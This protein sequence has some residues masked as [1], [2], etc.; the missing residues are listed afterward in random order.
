[1]KSSILKALLVCYR[2][3]SQS[4]YIH[5]SHGGSRW[6]RNNLHMLPQNLTRSSTGP[7]RQIANGRPST[8]VH[9]WKSFLPLNIRFP[10]EPRGHL[11][12]Q[13]PLLDYYNNFYK[14]QPPVP[15]SRAT[16][17]QTHSNSIHQTGPLTAH[18]RTREPHYSV[19]YLL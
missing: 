15:I 9:Q 18:L 8:V 5:S 19:H 13:Q 10:Y 16:P 7:Y 11:H 2:H 1:M 3:P 6:K 14:A 17:I 4:R 12:L